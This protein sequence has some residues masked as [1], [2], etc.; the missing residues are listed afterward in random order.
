MRSKAGLYVFLAALALRLGL[1][2]GA[3]SIPEAY[4][5]FDAKAYEAVAV[6]LMQGNGFIEA[7]GRPTDGRPPVY[8]LFLAAVYSVTG[9]SE[10]AVR[11]LQCF[12]DSGSAVLLMT[13]TGLIF[14]PSAALAAGLLAA[15]Y[16]PFILYSNVRLTECL[17][18]FLFLWEC[19]LLTRAFKEGDNRK[20]ALA[21]ILHG[22]A[23]LV[24][25][26]TLLFPLFLLPVMLFRRFRGLLKGFVLYAAIS[27]ALISVWT[28][29]NYYAHGGFLAVN[30]GSG[31]LMWY[32]IQDD[33]WDGDRIRELSPLRE[34]PELA[35]LPR[36]EMESIVGRKVM[37]YALT[38]PF[39]YSLKLARNFWRLWTLPIGKVMISDISPL[40]GA[41]Y[42]SAHYLLLAAAVC[43]FF[44]ITRSNIVPLLPALLYLAYVSLMHSVI[45]G[46]PR[47]R[48][49]YDHFMLM[50]CAAGLVLLHGAAG[51][52]K[53]ASR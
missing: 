50:F 17:F 52:I 44:M 49:P 13:I 40:Y 47:Y 27:T 12:I 16:P 21:G 36:H 41:L 39:D 1:L 42:Q 2:F 46:T 11:L 9:H 4:E 14:P 5:R 35:E 31:W 10:F 32:A 7:P 33:A 23:V 8:P 24:R 3:P 45:L 29:R 22:V 15:A 43:G 25:A 51:K 34:Y 6:N 38:N 30:T 37:K 26:P 48:L 18:M 28:V 19:L 53:G 20:F